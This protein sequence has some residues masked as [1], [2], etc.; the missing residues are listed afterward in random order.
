[1]AV[2]LESDLTIVTNG[3]D[4]TL[5]YANLDSERTGYYSCQSA[6]SGE[7]F[8]L[9]TTFGEQSNLRYKYCNISFL[10]WDDLTHEVL[11]ALIKAARQ[12]VELPRSSLLKESLV[13]WI[14]CIY[15]YVL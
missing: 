12:F 14:V 4:T 8:E 11:Y 13:Y 10:D 6:Q 7:K 5:T 1:M 2:G 3:K 9:F 15:I